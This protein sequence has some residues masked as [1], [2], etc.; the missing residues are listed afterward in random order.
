M[1]IDVASTTMPRVGEVHVIP[2]HVAVWEEGEHGR[3][4]EHGM[5]CVFGLILKGLVARGWT[6]ERDP[7]VVKNYPSI[8][9][10][11]WVGS[12]G[13]LH[14]VMSTGGRTASIDFHV[15]GSTTV[16]DGLGPNENGGRYS[17]DKFKRMTPYQQRVCVIEMGHVVNNMLALGYVPRADS[18]LELTALNMSILRINQDKRDA[19]DP[20]AYFNRSWGADRFKRDESGWP[21]LSEYGNY[22]NDRDGLQLINGQVKHF[23]RNGYLM[24]A[25]VFTSMNSMWLAFY[26][27][28]VYHLSGHE[29]FSCDD[30]TVLPR[31]LV[32][33]QVNRVKEELDKALKRSDY[34]R[35]SVLAKVLE[36]MATATVTTMTKEAS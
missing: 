24:R 15:E 8:A 31:R 18:R 6:I 14:A 29:L 19:S 35:V 12:K 33:K 4:D 10:C 5:R 23:R 17:F 22:N 9:N 7:N 2:T 32:P 30:P 16:I 25:T 11:H 34:K 3:I 26:A 28:T 27:G 20:L 36:K 21:V 1:D 13:N